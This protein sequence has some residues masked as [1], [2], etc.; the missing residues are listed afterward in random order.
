M[1][2]AALQEVIRDA[3]DRL[4]PPRELLLLYLACTVQILGSHG[5]T[6]LTRVDVEHAHA[7]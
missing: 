3:K 1:L 2:L 4:Q 5:V 6:V 7:G